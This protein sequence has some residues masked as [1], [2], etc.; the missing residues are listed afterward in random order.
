MTIKVSKSSFSGNAFLYDTGALGLGAIIRGLAIDNARRV[1]ESTQIGDFTDNS[2]GTAASGI[3]DLAAF[4]A[5]FDA[6]SA[7]G[8]QLAAF[9]TAIGKVENALA[10][11]GG[12]LNR[13]RGRLGLSQISL[14][15]GAIATAGTIPAQDKTVA[16]SNGTSALDW[17]SGRASM[18]VAKQ[19]LQKVVR[20]FQEVR[21]ALGYSKLPSALTGAVSDDY[22]LADIPTAAA[23]STGA[24]SIAKTVVDTFLTALAANI[25]TIAAQWNLMMTQGALTDLTDSSGGTASDVLA[26]LG[27]FTPYTTAGTDLAPKAGFDTEIAKWRNNFADLTARVN[28]LRGKLGLPQLTDSS[29]GT[30]NTT[31]ESV[32]VNL[33]AVTG[34]GNTGLAVGSANTTLTAVK[35]NLATLAAA[36]NDLA[37]EFGVVALTDN[38]GGTASGSKTIVAMPDSGAG[39]DGTSLSS[40]ADTEVDA[41]L[42]ILRNAFASLAAKLNEMTGSEAASAPLNVV[43]V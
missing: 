21:V 13:A 38:T 6:T 22:A 24:S 10:V 5:V 25:A 37:D 28:I 39:V 30:A 26:A 33:T 32:S 42:V 7:G 14:G 23:S 40:A 29:A 17:A 18:L 12:Y 16:T 11:I 4:P 20:A 43:A 1:I 15:V 8:A 27:A 31:I 36:I 41:K 19:N 35:N 34:S 9:N 2:T 3:V